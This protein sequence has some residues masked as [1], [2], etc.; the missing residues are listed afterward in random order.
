MVQTSHSLR[1]LH[2]VVAPYHGLPGKLT[3]LRTIFAA[4]ELTQA[5]VLVVVDPERPGDDPRAR[6]RAHHADRPLRGRVPRAALPAPSARRRARHAAGP[7]A[8]ARGLR[9]RARR[10][11]RRRV[12]VLGTLRVALPRAGHLEP[13][14]RH[15]SRSIC[16]CAPRR[17]PSGSRSVRS[18]AR[19]R[20][21]AG[22]RTT[23]R[24]AV[25]QIVLSLVESLRAHDS[26]WR[27]ANGVAELPHVGRRSTGDARR[28]RHGT[29]RRSP[30]RRATTSPRS[31]PLLEGVLEPALLARLLDDVSAPALHSTTSCGSGSSMRSSPRR[32]EA[33]PASSTSPPCSCRSICGARRRSWR[34]PRTK[35]PPTVQARLDSLCETFQRLKPVL[36]SSWSAEV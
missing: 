23:L 35:T 16:G 36:V 19:R 31:R 34:T 22:A 10:A 28:R 13:G 21:A 27:S 9:R 6:D 24:E 1:T 2:R 14:G 8:G 18:G 29:T 26:F 20:P 32:A 7:P 25:Q 11:A 17:W 4:A 5:K 3:A 33:R 15:G 30:S 12:L